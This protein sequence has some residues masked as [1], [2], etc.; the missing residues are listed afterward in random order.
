MNQR[1][2]ELAEQAAVNDMVN[3][4]N[5]EDYTVRMPSETWAGEFAELIIQ[6]CVKVC[7]EG[8]QIEKAMGL[9][10]SK[11]IKK[12]FGVEV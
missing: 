4:F 5:G 1:I 8:N 9:Y 2:K 11:Q 6:E 10:Y 12:H 7:T 3:N